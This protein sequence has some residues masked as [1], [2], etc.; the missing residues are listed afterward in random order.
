MG[1]DAPHGRFLRCSVYGRDVPTYVASRHHN[2]GWILQSCWGLYTSW[3]LPPAGTDPS[4]EDANLAVT[5]ETQWQ[6]AIKYNAGVPL[7]M[8]VDLALGQARRGGRNRAPRA[9]APRGR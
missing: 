2:W 7:D 3:E 6:E 8:E 9:A 5:V 1:I 4:L